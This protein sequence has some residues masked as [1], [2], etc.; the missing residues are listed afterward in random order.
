MF[1]RDFLIAAWAT[2]AVSAAGKIRIGLLGT[3]HSHAGGKLKVLLDS[4]DYEV[5]GV[6]EPDVAAR[7]QRQ[8]ET[9]Y[10]GQRWLNEDELL[11]DRSVAVVAVESAVW[12]GSAT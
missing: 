11:A 1:R 9:L 6:C 7:N 4:P 10:K 12:I 3:Q 5:A 2:A 8:G